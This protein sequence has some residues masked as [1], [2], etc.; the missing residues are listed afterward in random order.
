MLPRAIHAALCAAALLLAGCDEG[1]GAGT[2]SGPPD[3]PVH[4]SYQDGYAHARGKSSPFLCRDPD[5]DAL[6]T[7]PDTRPEPAWLSCDAAGCHG[8]FDY[9][10]TTD[11]ADRALHGA[12]GPSC[13]T[14]HGRT[15]SEVKER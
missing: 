12:D 6:V 10:P 15:W 4:D 2:S 5:T 8:D 11:P 13:Y 7:C 14:C 1:G 9:S 3:E